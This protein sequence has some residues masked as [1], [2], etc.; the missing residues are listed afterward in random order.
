MLNIVLV[1]PKIPGNVGTIGRSCFVID[2]TLHLVQP[3][4]FGDITKKEVRRAGLDYWESLKLFEYENLEQ[5]WQ[6]NPPNDRHF[7]ATTKAKQIYFDIRYKK[8]DFV[9]FGA[10]DSGLDESILKKYNKNCITVPM[11]NKARSLNLSNTVSIIAYEAVR[12]LYSVEW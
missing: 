8:D 7:F 11:K 3:Y 12:Q 10:E 1:H 5:F 4:G 6:T 2:A 9:Y